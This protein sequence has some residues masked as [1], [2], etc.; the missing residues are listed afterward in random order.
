ML[1]HVEMMENYRFAKHY[2]LIK[3]HSTKLNI[4]S[5]KEIEKGYENFINSHIEDA[6]YA[7]EV[8]KDWKNKKVID[9]G[10]GAGLPGIP[11]CIIMENEIEKMI[12]LEGTG[13][14][15]DF[16]KEARKEMKLYKLK[17]INQRAET[18][19]L[20]KA[21]TEMLDIALIR[22]VGPVET[23][24]SITM[25]FLRVGGTALIYKGTINDEQ[26][27]FSTITAEKYGGKLEK[28]VSYSLKKM[29][30]ERNILVIKKIREANIQN[31]RDFKKNRKR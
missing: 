10:S 26:T 2:E 8:Q 21:Y 16:L 15:A 3:E 11:I 6:L 9:I 5:K 28:L 1:T 24:I 31:S 25:P 13:K 23:C 7:L 14:K 22:A 12:L 20:N 27:E 29:D 19:V 18:I 17:V 4:M 30:N